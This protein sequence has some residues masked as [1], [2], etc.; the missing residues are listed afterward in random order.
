M[1]DARMWEVYRRILKIQAG[2]FREVSF[3]I[4]YSL[5]CFG[6]F[7]IVSLWRQ[8]LSSIVAHRYVD[9]LKQEI[10]VTYEINKDL[11]GHFKN[12]YVVMCFGRDKCVFQLCLSLYLP[13]WIPLISLI[14]I[15][16]SLDSRTQSLSVNEN[17]I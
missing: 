12:N 13:T 1:H 16:I 5:M 14:D 8:R 11:W 7:I 3:N 15:L 2:S 10:S 4:K 9:E 17:Y 6:F